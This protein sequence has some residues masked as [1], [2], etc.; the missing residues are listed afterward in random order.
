[1]LWGVLIVPDVDG[2]VSSGHRRVVAPVRTNETGRTLID[3]DFRAGGAS[4]NLKADHDDGRLEFELH[5]HLAALLYLAWGAM[6]LPVFSAA[7]PGGIAQLFGPTAGYLWAYPIV[8]FLAGWTAERGRRGFARMVEAATIAELVLF[9]CGIS[10]LVAMTHSWQRAAFF[11]AYPFFF[12]EVVK[13]MLVA[14]IAI[15]V[16]RAS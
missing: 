8:A 15:R 6:G 12:A 4:A 1:M 14:G 3:Q 10:W 9:A 2:M 11:G 13:V 16:R 7:G 5:A